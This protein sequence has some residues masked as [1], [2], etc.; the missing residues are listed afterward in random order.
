[1]A[2]ARQAEQSAFPLQS[3]GFGPG[4]YRLRHFS[5][6]RRLCSPGFGA[7]RNGRAARIRDRLVEAIAFGASEFDG[8]REMV[9]PAPSAKRGRLTM[10]RVKGISRNHPFLRTW[11]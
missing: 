2:A 6:A 11:I 7:F 9:E 3:P 4:S 1:M 8:A 10:E 5:P